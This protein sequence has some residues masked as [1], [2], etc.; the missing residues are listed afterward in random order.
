VTAPSGRRVSA[1]TRNEGAVKWTQ[2]AW[3][4]PGPGPMPV[5]D[6]DGEPVDYE[7]AAD[8]LWPPGDSALSR[9]VVWS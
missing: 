8:A 1:E 2:S 6:W 9:G 5:P 4:D 7:A 3:D